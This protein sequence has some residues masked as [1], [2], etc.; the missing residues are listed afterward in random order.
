MQGCNFPWL[1]AL[2]ILVSSEFPWF[3]NLAILWSDLMAGP[4]RPHQIPVPNSSSRSTG[5][6][7]LS[8]GWSSLCIL[9][10]L[11][12][13]QHCVYFYPTAP[14]PPALPSVHQDSQAHNANWFASV[15]YAAAVSAGGAAAATATAAAAATVG[16]AATA[17]A[18]AAATAGAAAPL[19][20]NAVLCMT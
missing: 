13:L 10:C 4:L 11:F 14:D 5:W 16:G 3:P 17:T 7:S 18:V 8:G 19:A 6:F 9:S 12:L 15:G 20:S 2:V 1:S